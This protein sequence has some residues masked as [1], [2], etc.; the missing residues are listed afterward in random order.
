[1]QIFETN[2]NFSQNREWCEGYE[3]LLTMFKFSSPTVLSSANP[4]FIGTR[5]KFENCFNQ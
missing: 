2:D 3:Q 4:S 1:M 5:N